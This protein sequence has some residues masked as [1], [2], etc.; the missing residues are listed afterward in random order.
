M[1]RMFIGFLL[2]A[3]VIAA[4]CGKQGVT[5]GTNGN[6][7][8]FSVE[9]STVRQIEWVDDISTY[10]TIKPPDKVEIFPRMSGR[11]VR[12]LVKEDQQVKNDE[13]VAIVERDEV[14]LTFKPVEVKSTVDGRIET[15]YFKEGAK[16][17]EMTPLMSISKQSELK[18][19]VNLFETDL[20]R[21]KLGI[22][23]IITMDALPNKEFIG[24]VTQIK[25]TLDA[26]SNK[27]LVEI[28]LDGN[29]PEIMFGMFGRARIIIARRPAL[30][31]LPEAFKK[32]SGKDAVY[33]SENNIA[34]LVFVEVGARK[35]DMIEIKSG[36][37]AGQTVITFASDEMK[38][39]STVKILGAQK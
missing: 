32:V 21:I 9:A 18:L 35:S 26:L 13:V 29:H 38:D 5:N 1:R 10:G 11:L 6:I 15:V 23:S 20:A 39:G 19:V 27:G 24:K 30:V 36:L 16:V 2:A 7:K 4:G 12:L 8:T 37:S 33:T 34:K 22:E 14:G 17:N 31:I 28:S 3:F 25:P